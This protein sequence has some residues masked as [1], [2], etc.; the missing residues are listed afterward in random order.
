MSTAGIAETSLSKRL[1][2]PLATVLATKTPGD[3]YFIGEGLIGLIALFLLNRFA[4]AYVDK[5]GLKALAEATAKAT[6]SLLADIRHKHTN[7][8]TITI[9]RRNLAQAIQAVRDHGRDKPVELEVIQIL[10]IELVNA[11]AIRSQAGNT[12]E[13]VAKAF[14]EELSDANN[15]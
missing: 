8:K 7:E 12:A 6:R 15:G 2:K 11:G 10:I 13:E 5:L 4:G 1:D 9:S 14:V 3:L